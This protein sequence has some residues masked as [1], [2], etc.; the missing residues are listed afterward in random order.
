MREKKVKYKNDPVK[1]SRWDLIEDQN[2]YIAPMEHEEH[3]L[4]TFPLVDKKVSGSFYGFLNWGK[5]HFSNL[6]M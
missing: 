4:G 5:G 1:C 3:T 6:L 2:T